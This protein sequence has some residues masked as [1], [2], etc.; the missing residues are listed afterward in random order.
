L[1]NIDGNNASFV[2][3][4]EL[5]VIRA[6]MG[7]EIVPILGLASTDHH[8]MAKIEIMSSPVHKGFYH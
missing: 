3:L 5:S 6:K 1:L 4:V 8:K 7:R 2:E